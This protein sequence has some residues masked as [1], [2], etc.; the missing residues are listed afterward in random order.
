[1]TVAIPAYN[2]ETVICKT[3]ASVLANDYPDLHVI[4]VD[5][6]SKDETLAVVRAA[7]GD[8]PR[9]TILSK[10]NGG[11]AS[12]LNMAFAAATTEIVVCMDGDTLFVPDTLRYLV[13]QFE[14]P[15]VGAVAGNV[16]VGNRTTLL[17]HWQS[18]E[19]VTMQNFDRTAYSAM[20]AVAVIPGAAGAWRRKA[21]L[22]AGGFETNTLAEDADLTFKIRLQGYATRCENAALAYTEAPED[23]RALSKQRF[24]WA[25]GIL[26]ALWKHRRAMWRPRNGAFG[27][28]VMPSMWFF[29]FL[30]QSL[31]P[32]VDATIILSLFNGQFTAVLFYAVLYFVIDLLTG[33]VAFAL[34]SEDKRQLAWLFWQRLFYRE[35]MYLIILRAFFA[36]IHGRLV[37]WGK[38]QR[39]A[40]VSLPQ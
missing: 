23:L 28:V 38:L 18:L 1:M 30:L 8:D 3:I 7:Y 27:L 34:D 9:V 26:Q 5:D 37:G 35:F 20:N 15:H 16:K 19:Y 17:T 33:V 39:K 32:V 21:V 13:R 24:R 10:E 14:D 4:V 22:E 40:T 25:Y 31:A 36:A 29:G 12:A 11:K 2:E 6:G